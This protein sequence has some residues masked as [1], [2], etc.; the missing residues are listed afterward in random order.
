MSI[1]YGEAK[2]ILRKYVGNAGSC[3]PQDLDIFVKKV[4]QYIMYSGQ[5]GSE[6]KFCFCAVNGCFTLPY[7]LDV[8]LKVT[9]DKE[10]GQV[11]NR[12]YEFRTGFDGSRCYEAADALFEEPN[13]YPTVYDLPSCGAR[14]GV[15]GTSCESPDAHVIVYG[16]DTTGREVFT[17]HKDQRIKG[18]YLSIKKGVVSTSNVVFGKITEVS[19]TETVGYVN[20]LWI[21][22]NGE[23]RGFLADYSPLETSPE[24][25]RVRITGHPCKPF[26]K[27]TVLGR[28]RLKD[29]YADDERIPFDNYMVLD[30][31]GQFV[32]SS[33][34]DDPQGASLKD[35]Q[36]V[37]LIE[38]EGVYKRVNT[39]NPFDVYVP[40]SPGGIPKLQGR[41]RRG[42]RRRGR[43]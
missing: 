7:E 11:W 8:P 2:R 16:L 36:V 17:F 41:A 30:L 10:A 38:R 23:S 43:I 1:S 42:H 9:I 40:L 19:K 6:R 13:H 15:M 21:S 37:T 18:E 29:K 25:R 20:A 32:N 27:I 5:H 14:V 3:N 26:H 31:A 33:T 22:E 39:G 24:Y 35:Q 34:N 12:W 4:L 28:I